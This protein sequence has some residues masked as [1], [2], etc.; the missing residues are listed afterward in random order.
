MKSNFFESNSYFIDEK[1]NFL[2]F[3]NCYQ[4]YNDKGENIG[5]IK[6]KLS[7][8][9]KLLRLIIGK[10]LLPFLLEIKNADDQLEASISRGWTFSMSKIIIKNAQGDIIGTIIQKFNLSQQIFNIYNPSE[11]QIAEINGDWK[12]RNFTIIDASGNQIGSITKK[13][14]GAMKEIFTSADK[15]NVNIDHNFSNLDNK[16]AIFSGAITIDM[17]LKEG[18]QTY[19]RTTEIKTVKDL[20]T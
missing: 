1:V 5:T 13:W 10:S 2:K 15:Y 14:A 7:V 3:E 19:S 12:A 16:I 4:I 20:F 11:V 17:V 6:Q 8:G 9:Q 18:K